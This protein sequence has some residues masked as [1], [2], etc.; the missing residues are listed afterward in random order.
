MLCSQVHWRKQ[1][2]IGTTISLLPCRSWN[3]EHCEPKRRNQLKAMAASGVPNSC[4][5]LTVN[6]SVGESP[7]ERYK[8][9]HNSWKL[10]VKRILRQFKKPPAQRWV[11]TTPEGYEY[12]ELRSYR[13]TDK[14]KAGRV[15]RLHYMAFAEETE[16]KEPHLHILLRTQ[17]IPQRWISQQMQEM[18]NSPIVW[19]EKIK[20]ARQAIAYVTKYV[21]KAP[22]Q[23]GKCKRYWV[24]RLYRIKDNYI[25]PEPQFHRRNSQI[26][27][28]PFQEL[29]LEIVR[30][31]LI[32]IVLNTEQLRLLTLRQAQAVYG[33]DDSFESSPQIISSYLWLHRWKRKI[34]T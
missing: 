8:I 24:S 2:A 16:A 14:T 32:P 34:S 1:E 18:Q 26:I 9:L 15:K 23:F 6:T 11:L 3:C 33:S 31:G 19:I 28:Q 5:T 25:R 13:I 30:K 4:L 22:A 10:L 27:R 12:Q 21:T 29:Y 17:Y 7:T 20:G